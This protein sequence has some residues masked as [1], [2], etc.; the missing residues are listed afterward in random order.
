MPRET[1]AVIQYRWNDGIPL[2]LLLCVSVWSA[3]G[4]YEHWQAR[5]AP[6]M[7]ETAQLKRIGSEW[8]EIRVFQEIAGPGTFERELAVLTRKLKEQMHNNVLELEPVR[9]G[10]PTWLYPLTEFADYTV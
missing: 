6:Q 4:L 3:Q 5:V 1:E 9:H 7:R 8:N 2:L 10:W